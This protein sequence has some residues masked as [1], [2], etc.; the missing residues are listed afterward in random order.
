MKKTILP[1]LLIGLLACNTGKQAE[2]EEQP[3]QEDTE[4]TPA[5]S[6]EN[7][8]SILQQIPSPLEVSAML[9]D[10]GKNY[11][12]ELINSHENGINYNSNFKKAINLGIYGTDLGYTSIY[13]QN[14]D[15]L[16]LIE[17]IRDLAN[18]LNIGQFFDFHVIKDLATSGSNLD[19]LLLMTTGNFN[20]MNHYLQEQNRNTV[21]A[22]ILTGGWLEALHITC[23]LAAIAEDN[24]SLLDMVGEQKI[25]LE[26]IILLLD[27]YQGTDPQIADLYESMKTL[28][29]AFLDVEILY[30]YESSSSE[31]V[32]GVLVIK[33]NSNSEVTITDESFE[34]IAQV[35]TELR[36]TIVN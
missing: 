28:E 14:Q 30:T 3:A 6:D 7:V 2:V 19:S 8:V 25:T 31:V 9:K 11:N 20:D 22:L 36:S 21:S 15:G 24:E 29:E 12:V 10:N 5:I 4:T 17:V 35:A 18:D 26:N 13:E 34:K 32:D 27:A 1:F 33:D 23:E 16:N